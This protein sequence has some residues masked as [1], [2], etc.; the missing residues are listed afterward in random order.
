MI[1]KE[2]ISCSMKIIE[3]ADQRHV[4]WRS[5]TNPK[6]GGESICSV[7]NDVLAL[8]SHV[9]LSSVEDVTKWWFETSKKVRGVQD[10]VYTQTCRSREGWS[11]LCVLNLLT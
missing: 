5:T 3:K 11:A 4:V 7:T 8:R 2:M 1:A 9:A 10:R 6:N